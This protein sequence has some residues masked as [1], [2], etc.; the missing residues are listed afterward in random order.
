MNTPDEITAFL[1]KYCS[2]RPKL[3]NMV[4][5]YLY[6]NLGLASAEATLLCTWIISEYKESDDDQ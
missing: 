3:Y 6:T 5:N 1:L 2:S 4:S